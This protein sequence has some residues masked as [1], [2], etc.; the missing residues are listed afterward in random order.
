MRR[1]AGRA[2]SDGRGR[3]AEVATG[4]VGLVVAVVAVFGALVAPA[5]SAQTTDAVSVARSLIAAENAH[6]V[7]AVV[8]LF[9]P[10]AIVS[11]PTG[12]LTSRAEITQWQQELAA[13][14]FHAETTTPVA[15]TPEVVTFSGTVALDL[16]RGLGLS[17]LES[18]WQLTVQLGK[19]TTFVF[20]FTP[21]ATARLTAAATGGGGAAPTSSS[22]GG[23]SSGV[24]TAAP[25][26]ASSRT[27]ALTGTDLVAPAAGGALAVGGGLLV[28]LA[29]PVRRGR[30]APG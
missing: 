12:A 22:G 19:V 4:L 21:A 2:R 3:G 16:F 26:T 9:A 18:T 11:L 17:S 23:S 6:N 25:A 13:G 20:D 1:L 5:A 24:A 28:L 8:D 30:R 7:A 27:L 10:G 15:V 29:I 14:N